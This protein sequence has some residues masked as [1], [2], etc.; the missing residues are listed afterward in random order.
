MRGNP[1]HWSN[2]GFLT[3]T[4]MEQNDVGDHDP[5]AGEHD[6]TARPEVD[7][8]EG[9]A[10][11]RPGRQAAACPDLQGHAEPQS[12]QEVRADGSSGLPQAD[13]ERHRPLR[14]D[15]RRGGL[16]AQSAGTQMTLLLP[17]IPGKGNAVL[18]VALFVL[19]LESRWCFG[20]IMCGELQ[21]GGNFFR[22]WTNVEHFHFRFL[23]F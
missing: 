16:P 3:L 23:L 4:R 11:V 2:S 20:R 18:R 5:A 14:A 17:G 10:H 22:I 7:D 13:D 12:C 9:A 19:S 21:H 15:P 1:P 6:R 8:Q